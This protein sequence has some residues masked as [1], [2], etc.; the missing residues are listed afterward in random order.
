MALLLTAVVLSAGLLVAEPGTAPLTSSAAAA[1]RQLPSSDDWRDVDHWLQR[2]L[3][4]QSIRQQVAVARPD[5]DDDDSP[6]RPAAPEPV[7]EL[8]APA[9]ARAGDPVL[10]QALLESSKCKSLRYS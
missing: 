2:Q 1:A 8:L 9:A 3:R 6:I 7:H 5:G 10:M 4:R